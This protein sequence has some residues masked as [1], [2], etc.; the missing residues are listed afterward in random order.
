MLGGRKLEKNQIY[1]FLLKEL[2]EE[3]I[4]INEPMKNHTNFKIGGNADFYVI[5]KSVEQVQ[6]VVKL[7]G[8]KHF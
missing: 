6:K 1:D 5:A 7:A 4:K 8:F 2:P 3:Q